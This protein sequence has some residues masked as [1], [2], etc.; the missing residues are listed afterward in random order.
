ME[1][2]EQALDFDEKC[3]AAAQP[4]IVENKT[5]K[6]ECSAGVQQNPAKSLM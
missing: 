4:E 3:A 2:L 1:K 5:L 6:T